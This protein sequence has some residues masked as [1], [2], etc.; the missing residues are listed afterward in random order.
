MERRSQWRKGCYH[1]PRI[2]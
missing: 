2:W 1:G